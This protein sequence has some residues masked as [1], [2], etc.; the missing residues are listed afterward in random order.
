MT[1][2]EVAVALFH[3]HETKTLGTWQRGPRP[4][5]G[6]FSWVPYKSIDIVQMTRQGE[7]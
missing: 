6:F 7:V 3:R 5:L 1:G 2:I 4:G